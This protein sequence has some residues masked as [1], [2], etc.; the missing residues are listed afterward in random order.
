MDI[1][2][3]AVPKNPFLAEQTGDWSLISSTTPLQPTGTASVDENLAYLF[4][5]V[6]NQGNIIREL[7]N[8]F[9]VGGYDKV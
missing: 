4:R 7:L 5:L 2:Q 9:R 3:I 1:K 6:N 8:E